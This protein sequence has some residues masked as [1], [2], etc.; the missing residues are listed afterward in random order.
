MNS[1]KNLIVQSNGNCVASALDKVLC[2]WKI[3]DGKSI[4]QSFSGLITAFQFKL[5][6]YEGIVTSHLIEP[7][8][9]VV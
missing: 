6:Q 9:D 3:K 8:F 1:N 7:D 4:T 5:S 2:V